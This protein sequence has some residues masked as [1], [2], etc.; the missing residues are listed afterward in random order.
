MSVLR[1]LNALGQ[2]RVD[3]PHLRSIDSSV[4]AD[5]DALAGQLI[6]GE[7]AL[8]VRGFTLSVTNTIGNSAE[9]LELNI[10]GGIILHQLASDGG[11][12]YV[13]SDSAAA[14]VLSATNDK[15]VGS[16][17]A[18]SVNF[19]GL[20]LIR[21]P[22]PTTVDSVAFLD[23]DTDQEV[24]QIVPLGRTLQYRIV[25]S[26]Q[27]FSASSNVL[28]I[29][30][31]ETSATNT[32][33]D[34]TDCRPMLFRLATGGDNPNIQSSYAWSD[35]TENPIV[36]TGGENPFVGEDKSIASLKSWIDAM[37]TS[38]WET[39]GG[40]Y[41]YSPVNRDN[42]KVLYG[43]PVLAQNSDNFYFPLVTS[44]A[45]NVARS[46]TTV[47]V[48]YVGHPFSTGMV[49]D[50]TPGEA[51]FP[52]GTKIITGTPTADTF[53]YTEAGSAV[54]SSVDLTY[55]S[56]LWRSVFIAFENSTGLY[57]TVTDNTTTGVAL[58]KDSVLYVDLVRESSA[59]VNATVGTLQTLG[60]ATIPGRRM[61]LAWRKDNVVFIRDRGFEV[62]RATAVATTASLGI[63]RLNNT[64]GSPSS[65]VVVSIMSNGQV[66][67]AATGGNSY[68]IRGTGN[69]SG[70][71]VSGQGGATGS[72]V[73]GTGG[74]SSSTGVN[75][76]GGAPDGTGV[77][78]QGDG[79]G[80]GVL[81]NGGD[82]SGTGVAGVGG[83][84]N[85]VGVS[86][87]GDGTGTGVAGVGGDNSGSGLF[88]TGGAANGP[89]VTGQGTGT[90]VGVSGTGGSSGAVG[91]VGVGGGTSANGVQ[92]TG[93]A[94]NGQG[95]VGFG[96]GTGGGVVGVGGDN[97]GPGVQGTGGAANGIGVVGAGTGNAVG[98]RFVAA[99]AAA[100]GSATYALEARDGY[101]FFT[102]DNPAFNEAFIN[103][104]TP[105][106]I[107]KAW[108][109]VTLDSSVSPVLDDGFNID[110]VVADA[111]Y[112]Y[113]N[114][115]QDFDSA[116]SYVTNITLG[117]ELGS[118][119]LHAR[120]V[121]QFAGGIQIRIANNAGTTVDPSGAGPNT[122]K[123][124]IQCIGA[125]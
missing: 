79:T 90:G 119:L 46:G 107:T 3:S 64:A 78:G 72:G 25:I 89:G 98:G 70:A 47:T 30:Q 42:V 118:A 63:V 65:P 115:L 36:Y 26:T 9:N 83:A 112:V 19:I 84:P 117:D 110:T 29:A 76:V 85:G 111:S 66:E 23:A 40:E 74:G 22:D 68:G 35:R 49:V 99:S 81:G 69:G 18:S 56:L 60:S 32:V 121:A 67:V 106:N 104:I 58:P 20:D 54:S 113:V 55:S 94:P 124:Y 61:I 108:A 27:N 38:V 24:P 86:G 71:G 13:A 103:T 48:T 102:A 88:G 11:T 95:V 93:S 14:E 16:F 120:I 41:W 116:T 101:F 109:L 75:G 34:I 12:L 15:V 91:V 62:G 6:S 8:V 50:L 105:K 2:M 122:L 7:R 100:P 57:N 37:M 17:T 77:V 114:F 1:S 82:N 73:F 59:T 92:G 45:G 39:R 33:V 53:T 44:T 80:R 125:Q 4:V 97:S 43:Q 52:A 21:A 51:N 10:A 87:L 123:I 96:D 28:P 31:V 5:F